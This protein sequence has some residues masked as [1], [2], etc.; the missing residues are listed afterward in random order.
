MIN[1]FLK[2]QSLIF[3]CLN[4]ST[5]AIAADA[6][7]LLTDGKLYIEIGEY[8]KAVNC[9]GKFLAASNDKSSNPE[10]LALGYTVQAYGM[11]KTKDQT[12]FPTIKKYLNKAIKNDPG[13]GYPRKFL[14][15]IS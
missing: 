6:D 11:W 10:A 4:I 3:I 14:E 13:W 15:E 1:S 8:E 12:Y 2:I 9:V 5:G 7:N